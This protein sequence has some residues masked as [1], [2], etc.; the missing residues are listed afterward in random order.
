MQQNVDRRKGAEQQRAACV[1]LLQID[2]DEALQ[3]NWGEGRLYFWIKRAD[4][5]ERRFDRAWF[6]FQS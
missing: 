6:Q 3:T 5:A 1:L 4:L 2:T